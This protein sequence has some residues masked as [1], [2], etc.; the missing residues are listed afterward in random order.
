MLRTVF[1]IMVVVALCVLNA[2]PLCAGTRMLVMGGAELSSDFQSASDIARPAFSLKAV[3]DAPPII[4][5]HVPLELAVGFTG[6][7]PQGRGSAAD[8]LPAP[9]AYRG[10]TRS[11]TSESVRIYAI[12]RNGPD[13][14]PDGMEIAVGL[15]NHQLFSRA[16]DSHG[17]P[18][19]GYRMATQWRGELVLRTAFLPSLSAGPVLELMVQ[20]SLTRT[21]DYDGAAA[22]SLTLGWRFRV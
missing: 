17:N 8:Y 1:C 11:R 14:K 3:V 21:G 5:R 19:P 22:V 2:A 16:Y 7:Y 9:N 18:M 13:H 20:H 15:G 12:G 6:P 4:R 10:P